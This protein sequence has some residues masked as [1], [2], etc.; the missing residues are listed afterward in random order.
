MKHIDC[1]KYAQEILDEA[2]SVPNKGKL[3]IITVGEDPA[4]KVYVRGKIRDCEYCGIPV[5]HLKLENDCTAF[6][7]EMVISF[8]NM[9]DDVAGIILQLPLPEHLREINFSSMIAPEKD[10][11]G[12][13]SDLYFQP[14]TPKGIVY[15]LKKE[16][17]DLTGKDVLII[18]RSDLVGKPLAKMLLDEDCTITVVHS[19]TDP[20]D[21]YEHMT[22][23]EI[24]VSAVGKAKAFDLND[25]RNARVVVDVGI[26]RDE[27]GRLCGD[28][29]GFTE[30]EWRWRSVTPVPG[31]V[32]LLTRA[33]LMKNVAEA[34]DGREDN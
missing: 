29:Y 8:Q 31:G 23:A 22:Y 2:R 27:N 32:G 17:G 13:G 19:K 28:F 20:N 9:N 3:V 12:L 34:S 11:D 16:L 14:C 21:L 7:L 26:N 5:E 10:V 15:L 18:G 1:A 24:V 6:E 4:S 30:T 33:M 25:C